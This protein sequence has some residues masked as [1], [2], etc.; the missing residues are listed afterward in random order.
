[1]LEEGKVYQIEFDIEDIDDDIKYVY[2][3]DSQNTPICHCNSDRFT[4]LGSE[5]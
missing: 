3:Y 2:V 5:L 4:L 1:M